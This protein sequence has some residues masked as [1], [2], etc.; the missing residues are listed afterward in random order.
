MNDALVAVAGLGL[1]GRGIV[2]CLLG[3]GFRVIGY[4]RSAESVHA[5]H[6]AIEAALQELVDHQSAS[7]TL[8]QQWNAAYRSTTDVNDLADASFVIESIV[9]DP[10]TKRALFDQLEQIVSPKTVIASNTSAIPI[11]T[12]QFGRLHPER[13]VGMHWAEPAHATRFLEL[14]RGEATGD[15]AFAAAIELA[16]RC[17]KEPS[18][19]LRDVPGFIANRIGYAMYREA[20]HLLETGV[21]DAETID[22]SFRNSVGLWASFCGP[23]RWI[24]LT[25]GPTLYARA[26]EPVLPSLAAGAELPDSLA[27]LNAAG[28][29]GIANDRGFFEYAA[30]EA[31]EWEDRLRD[32]AWRIKRLIDQERPLE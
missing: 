17:G 13:F 18:F 4:D 11:S 28:A 3:H 9:E 31:D 14:I 8:L 20:L 23:L 32:H 24:D 16:K 25:G 12:M 29:A 26:M 1:L 7:E 15:R 5:A 19:V 22:R 30:G 27:K 2:A 21:A 6:G 10:A